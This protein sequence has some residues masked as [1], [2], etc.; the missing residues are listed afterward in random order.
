M[1]IDY[2]VAAVKTI[3]E[4]QPNNKKMIDSEPIP[5]PKLKKI[6]FHHKPIRPP[7]V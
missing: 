2:I 7:V 4:K 3:G 1:Q 6:Q 5:L